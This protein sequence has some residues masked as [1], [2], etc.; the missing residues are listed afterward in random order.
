MNDKKQMVIGAL[1]HAKSGRTLRYG[2][3]ALQ[4]G[5]ISLA[6]EPKPKPQDQWTVLGSPSNPKKSA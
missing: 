3:V 6:A 5:G 4:A 1:I 2:Q